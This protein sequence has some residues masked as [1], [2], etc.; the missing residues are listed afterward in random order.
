MKQ[1]GTIVL[2]RFPHADLEMGK[3][4][5]ALLLGKL[6]GKYPDWLVCMISSQIRHYLP[7]VDELIGGG[8]MDFEQSGLHGKSVIRVERLAVIE[9]SGLLGEIGSVSQ[10]RLKQI[11]GRLADWLTQ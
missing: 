6:H 11:K 10:E 8:D 5:P 1:A 7:G 3:P 9:E 4:R 2:F